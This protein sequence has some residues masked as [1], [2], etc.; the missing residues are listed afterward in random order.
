[1]GEGLYGLEIPA[2]VFGDG[3]RAAQSVGDLRAAGAADR[4]RAVAPR[5]DFVAEQRR[6]ID[7]GIDGRHVVAAAVAA[8]I[9]LG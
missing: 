5:V 6:R 4:E 7:V 2:S 9:D 8:G 1:M 3:N